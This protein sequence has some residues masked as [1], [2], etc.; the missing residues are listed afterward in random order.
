MAAPR[1]LVLSIGNPLPAYNSLHSAGHF[2]LQSFQHLL[3]PHQSSWTA[4]QHSGQLCQTSAGHPYMLVQ[5]PTLMNDSGPWVLGAWEQTLRRHALSPA[6]LGLIVVH[7]ELDDAIGYTRLRS[8]N[9]SHHGHRGLKG[10][11][12]LLNKQ[13]FPLAR[14]WRISVGIGRP[15]DRNPEVVAGYVLR[16]IKT[17]HKEAIESQAGSRIL[18]IL[19]QL[20]HDWK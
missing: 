5:S 10:I 8:W 13:K 1:F 20:Q 6:E 18:S 2:A 15:E 9:A 16:D 12:A 4:E 7:D 19:Q 14:C 17:E 3:H 11:K